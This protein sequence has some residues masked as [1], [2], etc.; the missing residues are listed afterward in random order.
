MRILMALSVL[1]L[2][3]APAVAD[4]LISKSPFPTCQTVY[5][6]G[7]TGPKGYRTVYRRSDG[8]EYQ[9]W[10]DFLRAPRAAMS[11]IG[12]PADGSWPVNMGGAVEATHVKILPNGHIKLF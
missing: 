8:S 11:D 9:R 3:C 10:C 12:M 1:A 4:T 5:S 2:A 6:D 7:S